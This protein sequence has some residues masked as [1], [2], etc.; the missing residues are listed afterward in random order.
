M[1]KTAAGESGG[2]GKA[3]KHLDKRQTGPAGRRGDPVPPAGGA[4]RD[5]LSQV[6]PAL[7]SLRVRLG[8]GA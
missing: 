5:G 1:D 6:R 8:S 2:G 3:D 7:P 4:S